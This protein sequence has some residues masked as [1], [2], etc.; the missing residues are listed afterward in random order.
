MAAIAAP[1]LLMLATPLLAQANERHQSLV[2]LLSDRQCAGC[3]LQDAD[4]VHADL[5]GANLRNAQLQRANLSQARLDGANLQGANLSFTSLQGAY[6]QGAN[7][8]G[9][10]L[11]GTDLRQADLSGTALSPGALSRSH[12]GQ[13]KGISP[14]SLSYVELHNAGATSAQ[15]GRY[16]EAEAFF[17]AAI[18]RNPEAAISWLARGISRGQQGK[19]ELAAQDLAYASQLYGAM[20]DHA[21]AKELDATSKALTT[22][23]K[24]AKGGSG[25]G[26]AFLS[27]AA[28]AL[29]ALA[30]L[31]LKILMPMGL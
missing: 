2:K 11:E 16:P 4:L 25:A 27:G 20:G 17:S 24:K 1:A 3:N 30:P 23:P 6:L 7:L 5:R 22:N 14:T 21:L 10:T 18:G 8:L 12:W 28:S 13:A 29:S 15:Q 31:A 19:K 9:A 26:S